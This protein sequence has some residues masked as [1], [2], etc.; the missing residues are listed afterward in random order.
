MSVRVRIRRLLA[1]NDGPSRGGLPVDELLAPL[2]IIAMLALVVNDWLIKPSSAPR[3]LAGKLSDFA[4]LFAFP[5][6][7]TAAFD[8]FLYALARLGVRVDFTL[9]RWKLATTI[10]LTGGMFTAMKLSPDAAAW[11][12]RA[13][14]F[15]F[16]RAAVEVDPSDLLALVMLAVAWW[17]GRRVIARVPYGR[18]ALARR[19]E[20]GDFR[21]AV[22]CGAAPAAVDALERAVAAWL[23]GGDTAPV[24]EALDR[25]R[26]N[27]PARPSRRQDRAS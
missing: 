20:A 16:G 2:P 7:A 5:L 6:V 9:R 25:L 17:Y 18:L 27:L 19:R 10:A 23:A 21:D 1:G 24:V 26:G 12:A 3:W 15:V 14:G 13:L 22:A 11:V 4:G 8:L